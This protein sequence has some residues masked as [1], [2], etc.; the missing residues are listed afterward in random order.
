MENLPTHIQ[1]GPYTYC[2]VRHSKTQIP[3][4]SFTNQDIQTISLAT[5]LSPQ[6]EA[7]AL[8]RAVCQIIFEIMG[9]EPED[10]YLL[11]REFGALFSTTLGASPEG[12]A[13]V[14]AGLLEDREDRKPHKPLDF[15]KPSEFPNGGLG[16]V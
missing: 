4:D 7:A 6:R 16:D 14:M 12:F 3:A 1:V 8:I 9:N 11:S 2:I 13:W 15:P 10:S 5:T